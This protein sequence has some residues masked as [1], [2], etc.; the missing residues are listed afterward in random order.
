MHLMVWS[1]DAND[2]KTPQDIPFPMSYVIIDQLASN[3]VDICLD[4]TLQRLCK[5]LLCFAKI[6]KSGHSKIAKIRLAKF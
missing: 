2:A 5:S 1:T 6:G 4:N 3:S